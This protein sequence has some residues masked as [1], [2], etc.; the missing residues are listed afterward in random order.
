M[1]MTMFRRAAMRAAT[2]ALCTT[3]LCAMPMIAQDTAPPPPPDHMGGHG[4]PGHMDGEHRLAMLTKKLN[5]TPDQVT[6][7][8]AIDPDPMTQAKPGQDDTSNANADKH[9]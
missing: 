5:L 4:G 2:L 1:N 7:V 8:K 3:V 9:A 6:Q